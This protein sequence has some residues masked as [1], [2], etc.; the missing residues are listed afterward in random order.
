MPSCGQ[1]GWGSPPEPWAFSST[2]CVP[3][4]SH[5]AVQSSGLG[6]RP[7][8]HTRGMEREAWP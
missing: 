3:R 2:Y 4:T 5:V 8:S 6:L 1:P 7:W